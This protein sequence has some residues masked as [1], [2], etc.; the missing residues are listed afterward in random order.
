MSET[1]LSASRRGPA[2]WQLVVAALTVAPGAMLGALAWEHCGAYGERCREAWQLFPTYDPATGRIGLI[3][4]DVTGNGIIDTS[5]HRSDTGIERID[6]D[7]DEDGVIDRRLVFD[8]DG[9]RWRLE[10]EPVHD[11]SLDAQ[12]HLTPHP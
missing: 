11:E 8:E 10:A 7:L 1:R 9:V 12:V 6:I 4:R 3:M 2:L 5:V